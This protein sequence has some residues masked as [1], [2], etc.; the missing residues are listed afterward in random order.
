M[1]GGGK[2][3]GKGLQAGGRLGT[4]NAENS[5]LGRRDKGICLAMAEAAGMD[6]K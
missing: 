6:N 3:S 5:E 1:G 2:T 4:G